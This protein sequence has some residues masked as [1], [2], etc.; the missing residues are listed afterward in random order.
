MYFLFFTIREVS[1][2][3]TQLVLIFVV[4]PKHF[5]QSCYSSTLT[6]TTPDCAHFMTWCNA[7]LSF[8]DAAY[9]RA[10]Q[11]H[12]VLKCV[13]FMRLLHDHFQNHNPPLNQ[14]PQ[15]FQVCGMT[16]KYNNFHIN[17]RSE[18]FCFLTFALY[19]LSPAIRSL[20]SS[21][22][23]TRC[24][25]MSLWFP[26]THTGTWVGTLGSSL[27]M[28]LKVLQLTKSYASLRD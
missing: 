27:R 22:R 8:A 17:H 4:P 12:H 15:L 1:L 5:L 10:L 14:I 25:P 20:I 24:S 11:N 13:A 28:Q 6:S 18:R 2:S 26:N 9:R 19:L 16:F 21:G 3:L 7:V 23:M